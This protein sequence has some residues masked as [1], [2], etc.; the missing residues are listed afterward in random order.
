M[1]A[2]TTTPSTT[3]QVRPHIACQK[4]PIIKQHKK[5]REKTV[6]KHEK[7]ETQQQTRNKHESDVKDLLS[8][9]APKKKRYYFP[10]KG[11]KKAPDTQINPSKTRFSCS[12]HLGGIAGSRENRSGRRNDP[13]S[14]AGFSV[15]R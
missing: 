4:A 13:D 8:K 9:A 1:T 5:K 12:F 3:S 6:E 2:E 15:P 7:L 10:F 11:K 14:N